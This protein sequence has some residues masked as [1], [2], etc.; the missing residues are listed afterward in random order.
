[1]Q[2]WPAAYDRALGLT[3][4]V[5]AFTF[6]RT[7]GNDDYRLLLAS[8]YKVDEGSTTQGRT[9]LSVSVRTGAVMDEEVL[10]GS[11]SCPQEYTLIADVATSRKQFLNNLGQFD[12]RKEFLTAYVGDTWGKLWRY[13]PDS[14]LIRDLGCDQPIYFSPTVVQLDADD[15]TNTNGGDTY[16]V[17][18]T[19]SA[20]DDDTRHFGPSRM[21][22]IK[23][24]NSSGRPAL[25]TTFGDGG[26]ITL[27][28]DDPTVMCGESDLS[29]STCY[30]P[31][32]TGARP[33]STPMAVPKADGTGFF[34]LSNWYVPSFGGCGKGSTYFQVHD[35]SGNTPRLRQAIK[36]ADEP[37]LSPV[38]V[39]G[40]LM[41]SSSGGPTIIQGSVTT[42]V[43]ST[44][45]ADTSVGDIFEMG[46]WN[47]VQ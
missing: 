22:I 39:G 21:L 24:T 31:L 12:G 18:V 26:I 25:D 14:E 40:K 15:P 5:P 17:Q 9:F 43:I 7:D 2:G 36:V 44:K 4:S 11:G 16:L 41:I 30:T 23:E 8:G 33:L 29:G 34:I 27:A 3:V 47:E 20:L 45:A 6:H 1:M 19:N 13:G 46:G 37:V 42:N 38:V 35:F 32:P 28:A 10:P